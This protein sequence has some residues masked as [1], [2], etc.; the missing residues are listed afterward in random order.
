MEERCWIFD[1]EAYGRLQKLI[2]ILSPSMEEVSM[3]AYLRSLWEKDGVKVK[4]DVMGNI[5]GTIDE[6]DNNAIHI[7]LIAHMDTV[8]IQITKI[9]PNGLL[10]FRYIGLRPHVLLGQFVKVLTQKGV[11][12][13]AVGFDTTSQYGQPKGLIEEDL[14]LDIGASGY[15]NALSMVSIGDLAVITPRL[16]KLKN[17]HICGTGLDDRIGVFIMNECLNWFVKNGSSVCLHFIGSTQEEIGLRGA[18]II[19]A[20]YHLN[21][22]FVIDVDY[23][24]DILVSHD[25]QMGTLQLG[26]GVGLHIKSDNNPVLRK[27]A[28]KVGDEFNIAYQLSLGRFLCG[29]TDATSLQLQSGGIATMNINIP[30]RYMHSPIEICHINDI[31]SAVTLLIHT[32]N[33]IGESNQGSFIPGIN[34]ANL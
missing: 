17:M 9:C 4:T 2:D 25:N 10:Q 20:Q 18:G 14:W 23:A 21:A 3:A 15:E 16:T 22:C 26:K 32:I 30:C 33:K 8:A 19:A 12:E 24:T 28:S 1:S 11:I 29:G 7:G 5:H 13:G 27:L 6:G 34:D 31:E